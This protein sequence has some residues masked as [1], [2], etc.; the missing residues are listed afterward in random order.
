M[1]K[2]GKPAYDN[3]SQ[4]CKYRMYDTA[5]AAVL[6]CAAGCLLPD[7]LTPEDTKGIECRSADQ[8]NIE[9]LSQLEVLVP[10]RSLWGF[11]VRSDEGLTLINEMQ[12]AH[13]WARAEEFLADFQRRARKV[14]ER[15]GLTVPGD[16]E[17]K[18]SDSPTVTTL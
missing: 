6:S 2:Q 12:A 4:Q 11:T 7:E 8:A 17:L 18:R 13:D 5:G 3:E 10:G 9:Y 1:I 15:F 16:A 14:A